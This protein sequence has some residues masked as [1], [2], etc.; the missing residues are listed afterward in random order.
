MRKIVMLLMSL[1]IITFSFA[2]T[3]KGK[4]IKVS[5]GDTITILKNNEKTKI[6]L[7]G[8]DAPEKAQSYGIK[9]L[10]VLNKMIFNKIVEVEVKNKDRYGRLVGVIYFNNTNINLHMI[11]TGN[12]WWYKQYAK[13]EIEY[14][15][16][17]ERAKERKVGLWN[18]SNFISPWEYR[19]NK[20]VKK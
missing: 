9:S 19:K 5:D 12:A 15:K 20:R 17:E 16:A 18:G 14:K 1:L 8:I 11:E 13:N 3:I 7:Y 2:N 6:R 4:V 10:D